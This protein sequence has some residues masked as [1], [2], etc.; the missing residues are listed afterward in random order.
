MARS[1][2]SGRL[3][4]SRLAAPPT[5]RGAAA[6]RL[7]RLAPA[8]ALVAVVVAVLAALAVLPARTWL[9]QRQ[10]TTDAEAELREVEAEVAELQA[11]LELLQTDEEVER[12]AREHFDLVR[13]G[14]ESYRIVT[15]DDAEPTDLDRSDVD[16][17]GP[18]ANGDADAGTDAAEPDAG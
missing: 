1:A 9:A 4:P 18:G 7:R 12:M 11:E 3:R 17:I 16:P 14:E 8:L 15:P 13:P 6:A 5:R 2:P 10:N